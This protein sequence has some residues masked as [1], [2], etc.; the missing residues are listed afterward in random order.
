MPLVKRSYEKPVNMLCGKDFVCRNLYGE[1]LDKNPYRYGYDLS[2][3]Q[4]LSP[5]GKRMIRK[6][7]EQNKAKDKSFADKEEQLYND[8]HSKRNRSVI[9]EENNQGKG[10]DDEKCNGNEEGNGKGRGKNK[11]RPLWR[12]GLHVIGEFGPP[13]FDKYHLFDE[14]IKRKYNLVQP[15]FRRP[16]DEGD[17][18]DRDIH[19]L[20]GPYEKV[21]REKVVS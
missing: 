17:Y 21:V 8:L 20:G 3:S 18:F 2:A 5:A 19:I 6:F 11:E 16:K 13:V 15:P 4:N 7:I 9:F 14:P 12:Y 1:N 10:L